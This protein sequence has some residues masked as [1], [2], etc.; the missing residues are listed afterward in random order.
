MKYF[1]KIIIIL[2]PVL[3]VLFYTFNIYLGQPCDDEI[4]NT[5]YTFIVSAFD[6]ELKPILNKVDIKEVCRRKGVKYNL[7]EY[8][9]VDMVLFLSGIGNKKNFTSTIVDTLTD[10]NVQRLIFSGVAGAVDRSNKIGETVV[11]REWLL[12]NKKLAVDEYMLLKV[13]EMGTVRIVDV[14]MSTQRFVNDVSVLPSEVSMV[15]METAYIVSVANTYNV[16]FIAFRSISDM[17]DGKDNDEGYKVAVES[18][19]VKVLEFV[20]FLNGAQ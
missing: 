14:G 10:F 8:E 4:R 17:A 3:F 18:S 7:V 2:I 12:V 20:S 9:G 15:D 19:A 5:S 13:N 1:K 11:A 16:P 6:A